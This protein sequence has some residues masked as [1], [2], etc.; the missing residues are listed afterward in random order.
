MNPS[1]SLYDYRY[2]QEQRQHWLAKSAQHWYNEYQRLFQQLHNERAFHQDLS[3]S[4][5]LQLQQQQHQCG[6]THTSLFATGNNDVVVDSRFGRHDSAPVS[7]VQPGP[8]PPP[9]A[10]PSTGNQ[11]PTISK[12]SEQGTA[13]NMGV[14]NFFSLRSRDST[15]TGAEYERL[16]LN[17]ITP[18]RSPPPLKTANAGEESSGIEFEEMYYTPQSHISPVA[19]PLVPGA[20][21]SPSP[22]LLPRPSLTPTPV[23]SPVRGEDS[24]D[25]EIVNDDPIS[26]ILPATPAKSLGLL[27]PVATEFV[28]R[29]ARP[30]SPPVF[31]AFNFQPTLRPVQQDAEEEPISPKTASPTTPPHTEQWHIPSS[32][33][34]ELFQAPPDHLQSLLDFAPGSHGVIGARFDTSSGNGE[35]GSYLSSGNYFFPTT[36]AFP[37]PF[38][39]T[40]KMNQRSVREKWRR[41]ALRMREWPPEDLVADADDCEE[42]GKNTEAQ[43][44]FIDRRRGGV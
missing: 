23:L 15:G 17:P 40:D 32:L 41:S 44:S 11:H 6:S 38:N 1:S 13:E 22:V 18:L 4:L 16:R 42:D 26:P 5:S 27:S 30:R 29:I 12:P 2:Q 10:L 24:D 8:P 39:N 25:W 33:A 19:S 34:L 43:M 36:G 37:K 21:E 7:L 28:P 35:A 20:K 3:R 31:Q 9:P 14:A